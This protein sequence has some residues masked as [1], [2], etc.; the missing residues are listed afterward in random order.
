M[1][2]NAGTYCPGYDF[3]IFGVSYIGNPKPN[4]AVFVSKK[5]QY[6]LE[7]VMNVSEVL[8]FAEAGMEIPSEVTLHNAVYFSDSPQFDFTKCVEAFAIEARNEERKQKYILADEGYYISEATTIGENTYIEPGCVIGPDVQIGKNAC[9]MAGTI[10]K[11]A[12]IGDNFLC[13]ENAVIGSYSYTL[14]QDKDGNRYRIPTM[15]RVVIGNNVEVGANNAIARGTCGDTVIEDHVKMDS[16]VYIGHDS[17][18]R[19]NVEISAGVSVAGFVEAE[20]NARLG[21][22]ASIRNRI[23]IGENSMIGMGSV[24]TKS[25]E[26]GT[27]VVGNP[28]KLFR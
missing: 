7:K 11:H 17:C 27:T 22:G 19:K 3:D 9:I 2:I 13:N 1:K 16:L 25:V 26:E 23:T 20:Q 21:I 6:L 24:V 28:A 14:T 12:T 4:T 15:G 5:V 18:L 10:I 8:I